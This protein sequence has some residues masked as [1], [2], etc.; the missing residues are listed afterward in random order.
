MVSFLWGCEV[1]AGAWA[2]RNVRRAS[3]IEEVR[4]GVHGSGVLVVTVD[5]GNADVPIIDI[6]PA[7]KAA[8][9]TRHDAPRP[10]HPPAISHRS[11]DPPGSR[12]QSIQH[13]LPGASRAKD[14]RYRIS[15]RNLAPDLWNIP[16][17]LSRKSF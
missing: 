7:N 5:S 2:P 13:L 4:S 17:R 10:H 9:T 12:L 6:K 11:P 14:G 1:W 16:N 8:S 3:I 15:G